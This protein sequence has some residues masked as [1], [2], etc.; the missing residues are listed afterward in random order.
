MT[1]EVVTSGAGVVTSL[2][3]SDA[4]STNGIDRVIEALLPSRVDPHKWLAAPIGTRI[5]ICRD[6]DLPGRSLGIETDPYNKERGT[7]IEDR[8]PEFEWESVGRGSLIG[9]STSAHHQGESLFGRS[10]RRLG[11]Q[12]S[13]RE[14]F[15]TITVHD[16]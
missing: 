11:R 9:V 8:E 5:V 10:S 14:S 13:R 3:M 2:A 7:S 12:V 15:D 6:G 4:A 1:D 16:S